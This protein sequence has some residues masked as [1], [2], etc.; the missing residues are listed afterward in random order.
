MKHVTINIVI[1]ENQ[2]KHA[3]A[4]GWN[5]RFG[6][7]LGAEDINNMENAEDIIHAMPFIDADRIASV[8]VT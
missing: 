5:E 2:L 7:N 4:D 6:E 1:E 3:I 8:R